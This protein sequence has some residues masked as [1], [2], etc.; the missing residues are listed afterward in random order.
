ML[1]LHPAIFGETLIAWT[2]W[3]PISATC[4]FTIACG[5]RSVTTTATD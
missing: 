5:G 4:S 1:F 3:I 2:Y